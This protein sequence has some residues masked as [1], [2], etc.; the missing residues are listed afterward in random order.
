MWLADHTCLLQL[1]GY[2]DRTDIVHM[3]MDER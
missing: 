3:L 1:A 2:R